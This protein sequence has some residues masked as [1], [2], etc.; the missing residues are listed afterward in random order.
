MGQVG[1]LVY[2]MVRGAVEGPSTEGSLSEAE[3]L[4]ASGSDQGVDQLP[5]S[6]VLGSLPISYF[7]YSAPCFRYP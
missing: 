6:A 7:A 1:M 2:G 4:G 5:I 3:M